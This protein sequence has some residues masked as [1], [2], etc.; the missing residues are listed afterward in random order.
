MVLA[1]SDFHMALLMVG[2][3]S[4]VEFVAKKM[5]QMVGLEVEC[6]VRH[7]SPAQ[8]QRLQ[9]TLPR[10]RQLPESRVLAY[11][12]PKSKLH[13]LVV[14]HPA[15]PALQAAR[16]AHPHL[17]TSRSSHNHFSTKMAGGL[18]FPGSKRSLAWFTQSPRVACWLQRPLRKSVS[19]LHPRKPLGSKL[20]P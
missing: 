7:P 10:T 2:T 17:R 15:S 13:S 18:I 16:L 8:L 14:A 5:H 12:S 3:V 6:R 9:T 20:T 1:V 4:F 19:P 11:P